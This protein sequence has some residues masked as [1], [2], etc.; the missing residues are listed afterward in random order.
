MDIQRPYYLI[1][2]DLKR[3]TQPDGKIA[4]AAINRLVQAVSQVSQ[5]YAADLVLPMEVNYGDEFA[6]LLQ[7]PARIYDIIDYLRDILRGITEFRVAIAYGH[8][9]NAT[10]TLTQMGGAVFQ[11]ANDALLDLKKRDVFC[12][13]HLGSALEGQTL[14][15]LANAANSLRQNMTD[16]QYEVFRFLR[17]GMSQI[18]IARRLQK[19]EQS[20]STAA[21]RGQADLALELDLTLRQRLEALKEGAPDHASRTV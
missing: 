19:F 18:D 20:V 7:T 9:G 15:V 11:T 17:S 5:N 8:V 6:G 16:Y 21:K 4:T 10:D 12:E 2:G 13:W 3:S 14:T 1:L